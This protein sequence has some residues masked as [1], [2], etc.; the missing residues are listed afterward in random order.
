[1]REL[2]EPVRTMALVCVCFGLRISECLGLK[3]NDV[4]WL[5]GALRVER[6]I[7]HQRVGDVKTIY[8][9]D[10]VHRCGDA[11]S[12]GILEESNTVCL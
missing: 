10:D 2:E 1:V 6:S 12:T 9:P 5:N 11:R 4:D 3:W 8:S 7:V